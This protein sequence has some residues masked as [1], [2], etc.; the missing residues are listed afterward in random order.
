MRILLD[1]NVFA[2]YIRDLPN[3]ACGIFHVGPEI[4]KAGMMSGLLKILV[5]KV[6]FLTFTASGGLTDERRN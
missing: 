3:N 2:D 1:D 5:L 4:E 6:Y